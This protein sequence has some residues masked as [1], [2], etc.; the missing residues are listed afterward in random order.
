[1]RYNCKC[2]CRGYKDISNTK[3]YKHKYKDDMGKNYNSR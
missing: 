3:K 1:M 2:Y